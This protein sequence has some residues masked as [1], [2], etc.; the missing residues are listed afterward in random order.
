MLVLCPQGVLQNVRFVF[1]TT[2]EDILRNKGCSSCEYPSIFRTYGE[3][4]GIP[5]ISH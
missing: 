3:I 1:G 2:P 5:P 4:R